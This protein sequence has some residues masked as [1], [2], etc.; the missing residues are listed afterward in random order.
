MSGGNLLFAIEPFVKPDVPSMPPIFALV[1]P[2][3]PPVLMVNFTSPLTTLKL[4]IVLLTPPTST[5]KSDLSY[6]PTFLIDSV[7]FNN[8]S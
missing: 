8:I 3:C 1:P 6:V 5:A 4:S 7:N 2:V